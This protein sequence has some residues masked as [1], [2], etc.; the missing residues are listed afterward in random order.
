MAAGRRGL[1]FLPPWEG[2]GVSVRD[3]RI[4]N[5]DRCAS[6]YA[7]KAP[8]FFFRKPN[9]TTSPTTGTSKRTEST[10]RTLGRRRRFKKLAGLDAFGRSSLSFG[11][12]PENETVSTGRNVY[13]IAEIVVEVRN[14]ERG[15]SRVF[16][17][18][19]GVVDF[20]ENF[21]SGVADP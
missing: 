7:S 3:S 14:F 2:M 15:F 17:G 13:A 10:S 18:I 1:S 4:S 9:R 11:G 6:P 19:P 5:D 8:P 16:P 20:R 21:R 12:G